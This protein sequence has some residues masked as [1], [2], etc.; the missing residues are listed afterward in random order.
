MPYALVQV[1]TRP[2]RWVVI[3]KATLQPHSKKGMT[4]KKA[5]A[6]LRVLDA[7]AGQEGQAGS[8]RLHDECAICNYPLEQ[9]NSVVIC[10]NLHRLHSKVM[11]PDVGVSCAEGWWNS[12]LSVAYRHK[13]PDCKAP[14]TWRPPPL[15]A[16]LPAPSVIRTPF[17]VPPTVARV[18]EVLDHLGLFGRYSDDD[19]LMRASTFRPRTYHFGEDGGLVLMSGRRPRELFLTFSPEDTAQLRA[20]FPFWAE[21]QD[22]QGIISTVYRAVTG[23]YPGSG[24]VDK[25]LH[26]HGKATLQDVHV[27]R[28]P[29][30][31]VYQ[32]LIAVATNGAFQ[33]E[34]ANKS[35]DHVFHLAM[36]IRLS[37]GFSF[38]LEKNERVK[39][40]GPLVEPQAQSA[41]AHLHGKVIT[42][43]TFVRSTID[44][45]GEK[46][47]WA[48]DPGTTNCQL[49]ISDLLTTNG[50]VTPFLNVFIN[51]DVGAA[52]KTLPWFTTHLLDAV[53][54]IGRGGRGL[55]SLHELLGEGY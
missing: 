33:Q 23:H 7:V 6:Q 46:R 2:A 48:Y 5:Q 11:D 31:A 43:D 15:P 10:P 21:E 40:S 16:L 54:V 22:G 24:E 53:S 41:I 4:L 20:Q 51:Q 38:R 19:T 27:V 25:L 55:V 49:F 50:L 8:G 47:F 35:Y 30:N 13:C 44:S 52:V 26:A 18:V 1:S 28:A 34:I 32:K 42:L 29:I 9:D 14:M 36:N 45:V 17:L 37:D 12:P 39:V 3:T